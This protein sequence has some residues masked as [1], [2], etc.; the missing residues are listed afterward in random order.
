M[1]NNTSPKKINKIYKTSI[2]AVIFSL[3]FLLVFSIGRWIGIPTSII[4]SD[5]K[6]ILFLSIY[7]GT[8]V[9]I[10][11]VIYDA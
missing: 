4:P 2:M 6:L 8:M 3:V 10:M 1:K 5:S 9:A 11:H 7:G